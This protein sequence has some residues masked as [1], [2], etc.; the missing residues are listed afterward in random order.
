MTNPCAKRHEILNGIQSAA[1]LVPRPLQQLRQLRDT[2]RDLPRFV[3]RHE[4]CCGASTG[5]RLEVD[6]CYRKVVRIADDVGDAA[7]FLDGPWCG[8]AAFWHGSDISSREGGGSHYA[9]RETIR[10]CC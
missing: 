6:V 3:F 5:L 10:G 1:D 4:T 8:K 9:A 7:I 2:G